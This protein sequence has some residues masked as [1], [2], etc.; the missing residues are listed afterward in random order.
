MISK[1][2]RGL[3]LILSSPSGAGK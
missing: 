2:K 1:S 3:I